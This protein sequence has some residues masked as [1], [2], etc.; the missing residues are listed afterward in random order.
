MKD[1]EVETNAMIRVVYGR[2]E[3]TKDFEELATS[4]ASVAPPLLAEA[5]QTS[6]PASTLSY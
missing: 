4:D 6:L 5:K 1:M 3:E 2:L